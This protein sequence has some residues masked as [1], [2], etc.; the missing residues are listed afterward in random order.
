MFT[1]LLKAVQGLNSAQWIAIAA[2]VVSLMSLTVS[3][4]G[5]L[6]DRPKLKI[7]ARLHRSD[8]GQ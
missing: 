3:T 6:R 7:K 2:L 1:W 8:E 4:L 5:Y